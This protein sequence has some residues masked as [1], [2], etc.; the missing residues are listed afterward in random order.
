MA[1]NECKHENTIRLAPL[2]IDGR[3]LYRCI[4]CNIRFTYEDD[5]PSNKALIPLKGS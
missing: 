1:K 3:P 2:Y 5:E 4:D